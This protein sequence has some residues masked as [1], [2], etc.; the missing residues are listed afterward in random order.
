MAAAARGGGGGGGGDRLGVLGL[1]DLECSRCR[2]ERQPQHPAGRV[3]GVCYGGV[4]AVRW[5]NGGVL[6]VGSVVVGSVVVGPPSA[7]PAVVEACDPA[8]PC[9]VRGGGETGGETSGAQAAATRPEQVAGGEEHLSSTFRSWRVKATDARR[10]TLQPK[11]RDSK[12]VEARGQVVSTD[13]R[14]LSFDSTNVPGP[15]Y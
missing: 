3:W 2:R 1:S 4:T 11:H 14:A 6:L 15:S 9:R 12:Q 10:G 13:A 7:V 5:V 8:T